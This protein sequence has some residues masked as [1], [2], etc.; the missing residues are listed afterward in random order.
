MSDT[1]IPFTLNIDPEALTVGDL[2]DLEEAL[3]VKQIID[4]LVKHAGADAAQVRALPAR[5]LR[6]VMVNIKTQLAGAYDLPKANGNG[7][8]PT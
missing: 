3:K 2:E 1:A 7:S 6:A 4:W 8:S 5:E